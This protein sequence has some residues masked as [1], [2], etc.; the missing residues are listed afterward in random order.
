MVLS[1]QVV[2][3]ARK[4]FAFQEMANHRILYIQLVPPKIGQVI[5]L[6][7][8]RIRSR[9]WTPP[10]ADLPAITPDSL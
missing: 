3:M 8:D 6:A 1:F 5:L 10:R 7:D 4:K 2:G 9:R